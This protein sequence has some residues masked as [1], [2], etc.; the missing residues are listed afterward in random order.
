[1]STTLA[2]LEAQRLVWN[3]WVFVPNS[4]EFLTDEAWTEALNQ[5]GPALRLEQRAPYERHGGVLSTL[6][7]SWRIPAATEGLEACNC[8]LCDEAVDHLRRRGIR[9]AG[10]TFHMGC[11]PAKR[12]APALI[13]TLL[14]Q[15]EEWLPKRAARPR[16]GAYD[17]PSDQ[18]AS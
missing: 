11:L 13:E 9:A 7:T 12:L 16:Y 17:L 15:G 18:E 8:V 5:L 14:S 3:L 2:E 4:N 10:L 6:I 1:M